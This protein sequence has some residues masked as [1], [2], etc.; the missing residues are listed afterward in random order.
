M[1]LS[2]N[3]QKVV[4][5]DLKKKD[6]TF[7]LKTRPHSA[8]FS[9]RSIGHRQS[10]VRPMTG[11]T[12]RKNTFL[13][14]IDKPKKEI[15]QLKF[16]QNL[17]AQ[18]DKDISFAKNDRSIYLLH[19]NVFDKI[20]RRFAVKSEAFTRVKNGYE[21]V[22]ERLQGFERQREIEMSTKSLS[23]SM[24][25]EV[26]LL[27]EKIRTKRE[28][29]NKLNFDLDNLIEDLTTENTH[30]IKEIE[31][32]KEDNSEIHMKNLDAEAT[33]VELKGIYDKKSANYTK[34]GFVL[35]ILN[36]VNLLST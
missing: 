19:Q 24:Q 27:Q 33:Y 16:I 36:V 10:I 25:A 31:R 30:H 35:T 18:L 5:K 15:S 11:D 14:Q 8:R 22:I 6:V 23:T 20:I 4:N 9:S 32:L 26:I 13:V 1:I 3:G 21:Q 2:L 29:L 28:N 34:R 7:K 17:T 12:V